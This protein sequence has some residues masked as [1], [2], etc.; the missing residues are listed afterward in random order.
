LKLK[1]EDKTHL[2]L[3]HSISYMIVLLKTNP[4]NE[5]D[6]NCKILK[7]GKEMKNKVVWRK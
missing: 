1:G 4:E 7:E 2:A 5:R 3:L 6:L